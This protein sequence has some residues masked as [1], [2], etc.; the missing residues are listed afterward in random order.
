MG[1]WVG[2]GE[3]GWRERDKGQMWNEN[4]FKEA[5]ETKPQRYRKHY[6][7]I[8]YYFED[9]LPL[10]SIQFFSLLF[11]CLVL[12]VKIFFFFIADFLGMKKTPHKELC[13]RSIPKVSS[14]GVYLPVQK[15]CH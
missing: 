6:G 15:K 1:K 5:A 14:I 9:D 3:G 10:S 2:G 11:H 13:Y 8:M 4:R 12:S 7:N